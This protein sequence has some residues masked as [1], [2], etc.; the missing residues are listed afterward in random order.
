MSVPDSRGKFLNEKVQ[1]HPDG[2]RELWRDVPRY[3][4]IYRVSDRGQVKSLDRVFLNKIGSLWRARGKMLKL[5]KTR[6]GY[7]HVYLSIYG[8][9][10]RFMVH[11]LV[12]L[13]FVGSCP[14]GMETRHL[15]GNSS[16]N[17][18]SNLCW[19]THQENMQDSVKHGTLHKFTPEERS[20]GPA[21]MT[22][23]Q[24]T[25]R[26]YKVVA[27]MTPQQRKERSRKANTTMT[28]QQRSMR[29]YKA[30]SALTP[31]QRSDKSRNGG[32]AAQ[33]ALTPQQRKER[34]RRMNAARQAKKSN[35]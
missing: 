9:Q 13:T 23:Q 8:E 32:Y 34:S 11:R 4:G 21:A 24:R 29:S 27:S 28:P 7:P 2:S 1:I 15:D 17:N 16:N 6:R 3:K 18:L 12:L 25:E 31:Q 33:A 20:K 26:A 14:K 19:G 35:K 22:P 30:A 5:G 10:K